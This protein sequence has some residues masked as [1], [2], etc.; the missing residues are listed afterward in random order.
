MFIRHTKWMNNFV[1]CLPKNGQLVNDFSSFSLNKSLGRIRSSVDAKKS[2][3]LLLFI[4]LVYDQKRNVVQWNRSFFYWSFPF[5]NKDSD[6]ANIDFSSHQ[7]NN[8][9][10]Y[11]TKSF[12]LL[13]PPWKWRGQQQQ[14]NSN[15]SFC[16]L[17][18]KYDVFFKVV[19]TR[20]KKKQTLHFITQKK[21]VCSNFSLATKHS[22]NWREVTEKKT[23]RSNVFVCIRSIH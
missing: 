21:S 8:N 22:R 19:R 12:Q 15:N 4:F 7:K 18:D 17:L 20:W 5:S 10:E 11:K 3:V 13:F 6:K 16:W 23:D 2:Y 9:Q 14:N 1:V